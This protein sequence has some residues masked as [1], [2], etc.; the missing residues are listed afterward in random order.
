VLQTKAASALPKKAIQRSSFAA[1]AS[2]ETKVAPKRSMSK[3]KTSK[4]EPLSA[5]VPL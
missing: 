2:E 3:G 4:P 1:S 5:K